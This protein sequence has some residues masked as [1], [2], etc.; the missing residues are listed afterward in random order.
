MR[1][2]DWSSDVCSSDLSLAIDRRDAVREAGQ[3]GKRVALHAKEVE[4]LAPRQN[5]IE[6][7][8]D[9]DKA[10]RTMDRPAAHAPDPDQRRAIDCETEGVGAAL[11]V[12]GPPP[13][14]NGH[15][16][17]LDSPIARADAALDRR[18]DRT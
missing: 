13:L 6:M 8:D 12:L 17:R 18:P 16:A 11:I 15:E 14:D 10:F 9:R 3:I 7:V 5:L 2:S 4:A 1:I